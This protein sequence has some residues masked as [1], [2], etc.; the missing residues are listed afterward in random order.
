MWC[1]K[2]ENEYVEG[3]THCADCGV[4][5]VESLDNE[6]S[7]NEI[8]FEADSFSES[9]SSD[10]NSS[11]QIT[12]FD[13][14]GDITENILE[15]ASDM[16]QAGPNIPT[17]PYVSKKSKKEDVKSTAQTFTLVSI[18]GFILLI[19]FWAGIIPLNTATYMKVMLSVVMGTMFIIFFFVGIRS[20]KDLKALEQEADTEEDSFATITEWFHQTY[21][22]D[23]ID[24]E[25][26]TKEQE[27][28]LY[29]A[30]YEKMRQLISEAYEDLDPSF[31]DHIIETLYAE[32][33]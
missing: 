26:D 1:P 24:A 5:L 20:F 12:D 10:D 28:M 29:F 2:C 8:V 27:E 25:L 3:I 19:L 16:E 4:E 14:A 30:R 21:S 33:F 13:A 7:Q 32:L 18:V 11:N 22:T 6:V 23:D 31:L 17:H 9:A 15:D